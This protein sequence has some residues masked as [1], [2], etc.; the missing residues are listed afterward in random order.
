MY[1]LQIKTRESKLQQHSNSDTFDIQKHKVNSI[2]QSNV[3]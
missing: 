3:Q 1:Y 2:K